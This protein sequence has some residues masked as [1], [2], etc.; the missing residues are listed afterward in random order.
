M[1]LHERDLRYLRPMFVR[2]EIVD[3]GEEVEETDEAD[4]CGDHC[5]YS[6]SLPEEDESL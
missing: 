3:V 1:A 4:D 6:E 2:G 5:S